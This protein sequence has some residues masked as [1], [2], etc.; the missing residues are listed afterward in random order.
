MSRIKSSW[1]AG[2]EVTDDTGN[3]ILNQN[4]D[5]TTVHLL[6]SNDEKGVGMLDQNSP[7]WASDHYAVVTDLEFLYTAD[8]TP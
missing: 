8:A 3:L 4:R 2:K 7:I 6:Q 1:L 5:P